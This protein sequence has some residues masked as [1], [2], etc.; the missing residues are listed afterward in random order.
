[1]AVGENP[2]KVR[3]IVHA[4]LDAFRSLYGGLLKSFW[5]SVYVIGEQPL[6]GRS[7]RIIRQDRSSKQRAAVASRLPS[8]LKSKLLAYYERK[9]NLK[10][11]LGEAGEEVEL[12][13]LDQAER[14]ERI[15]LDDE[16]AQMLE[17]SAFASLLPLD[18]R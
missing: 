11:A 2:L 10:R 13:T 14:W 17:K 6:D 16:F 8:G 7:V 12:S 9:W 18:A 1:M 5:K 3:N 4:Q 15:V